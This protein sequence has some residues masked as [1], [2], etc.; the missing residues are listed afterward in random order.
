MQ[1]AKDCGDLLLVFRAFPS[2]A[3]RCFGGW[4]AVKR[5]F[6]LSSSTTAFRVNVRYELIG[7]PTIMDG[8]ILVYRLPILTVVSLPW[9]IMEFLP[10][11]IL[12]FTWDSAGLQLGTH[13]SG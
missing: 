4:S 10:S 2:T 8:P 12:F 9:H 3:A 7:G 13:L 1:A 6:N 5:S 11:R